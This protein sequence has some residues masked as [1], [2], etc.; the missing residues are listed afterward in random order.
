MIKNTVVAKLKPNRIFASNPVSLLLADLSGKP[1][2][3]ILCQAN[4][5]QS[6]NGLTCL[7]RMSGPGSEELKCELDALSTG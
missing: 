5:F 4:I 3:R 1:K 6:I 7:L 2:E